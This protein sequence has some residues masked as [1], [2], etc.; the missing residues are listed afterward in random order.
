MTQELK[1]IESSIWENVIEFFNYNIYTFTDNANNITSVIKVKNLLG[2]IAILILTTYLLRWIR[3]LVTRSMPNDDKAKFTTVF[4]FARW[5]VYIIVLLIVLSSLGINVTA[6]FA[7]SA[8]LLIGVG[9]ALQT[10]FQDIISGIF[11]LVDQTVHV[12]DII[13]IE[14]KVGRVEEIKLRTTRATTVDNKV[15][16]IPN[17]LYLENSLYN[18]TQNGTSTRESVSVGVAYGSDVRL[19]EKLLIEAANSHAQVIDKKATVV[20]FLDFGDS[21]L[22]FKVVF[23]LND[24]FNARI[25]ESDIRFEIDRLFRENNISIPFPQRDIHIIQKP[26]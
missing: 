12:G 6:V 14:G 9:L 10:L 2:V 26:N 3:K 18:W 24:S 4:S 23:T 20:R 1:K 8:A 5:I 22:N 7:A 19:V 16:I 13:E 21:S 25:P 11:I 17:H 15:L